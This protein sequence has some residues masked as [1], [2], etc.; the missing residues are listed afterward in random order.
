MG[1]FKHEERISPQQAAERLA[2]IAFTL[3]AGGSLELRGGSE[4]VRVAVPGEVVLKRESKSKG[5]HV[6]VTVRLSWYA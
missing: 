2:D 6:E 5:D 4:E 3:T 1:E